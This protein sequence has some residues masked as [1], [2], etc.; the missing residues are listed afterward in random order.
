MKIMVKKTKDNKE[1]EINRKSRDVQNFRHESK[2]FKAVK[3]LNRENFKNPFIHDKDEET[4]HQSLRN[5]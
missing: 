1:K 5:I 3:M 4:Y 2:M